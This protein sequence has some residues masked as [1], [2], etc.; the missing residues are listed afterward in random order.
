MPRKRHL[1][2]S[3][4]QP[5]ARLGVDGVVGAAD[6]TQALHDRIAG[7]TTGGRAGV[8]SRLVY[9]A[10]RGIAK[11]AGIAGDV[12]FGALRP[13]STAASSRERESVLA[14]FNGVLGDRLVETGNALAVP[15]R[16]RVEGAARDAPADQPVV[17]TSGRLLLLVHG[18]C[19][20]DL[21]WAPPSAVARDLGYAAV[22]AQYNTGL[23]ISTN[24]RE[25]ARQLSA[26]VERWPVPVE[27]IAIVAHSMGG[28]VTRSACRIAGEENLPWLE[29]LRTIVFLG[30]PHLGAPLER[31]GSFVHSVLGAAG[32]AAPLARLGAI[33]SAGITDLRH[34]NLA[35]E[36]WVGR[37]RFARPSPLPQS[38]P[39]PAGVACYAIAASTRA[40]PGR[41]TDRLI[42]DGLVPVPSAIGDAEDPARSLGIP[43]SRRAIVYRT[44]HVEMLR[45]PEVEGHI[46]EWLSSAPIRSSAATPA[47]ARRRSRTAP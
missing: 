35:D 27:E 22:Y 14:A 25:L 40:A 44:R 28:L 39:L 2:L 37:D 18:L 1:L 26:L 41:V 6:L 7:R 21:C 15:M 36:D 24:G 11:L 33:R 31:L 16:L 8:I 46:R 45:S 10:I 43:A 5:L 19:L 9:G 12:T 17:A 34:A 32:P 3:D 23:H 30:T 20:D 4:L 42:G 13:L 29:R 47:A 38:V